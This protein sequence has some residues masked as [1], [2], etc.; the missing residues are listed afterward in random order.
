MSECLVNF[1]FVKSVCGVPSVDTVA[2][3]IVLIKAII[4]KNNDDATIYN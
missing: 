2:E 4:I 1:T 3:N